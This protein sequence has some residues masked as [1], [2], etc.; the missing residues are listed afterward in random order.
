MENGKFKTE[1]GPAKRKK[2]NRETKTAL[3]F[4]DANRIEYLTGFRKRRNERK[5]KAKQDNERLLRE[6]RQRLKRKAREEK[7]K[8]LEEIMHN[9]KE[10]NENND[11]ELTQ[12]ES[13]AEVFE[14]ENTT[15]TV[16][17][18]DMNT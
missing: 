14:D 16:A 13:N 2:K 11:D 6:A 10:K 1:D 4:D 17:A 3:K 7:K 12:F 9:F 15:V 18:I 5:E 8:K